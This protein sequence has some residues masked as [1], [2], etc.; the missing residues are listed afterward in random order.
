M[1]APAPSLL[2]LAQRLRGL[3]EEHFAGYRVTQ[4]QLASALGNVAPATVSSWEN[5]VTPKPPPPERLRALARFFATPRSVDGNEPRILPYE[6][7]S[8]DEKSGCR[9]LE[10]EL[11]GLRDKAKKPAR[12]APAVIRRS[13][14]FTD[15]GPL[16]IICAELPPEETGSY[17]DPADPNYTKMQS[18][19][20]L[21][22]LIELHGHVRAEN[23]D[24]GVYFKSSSMVVPDDLSGHV[25]LLGGVAWNEVTQE[26]S[27][28]T[29]LP[30]RQIADPAVETGE[31]FVTDHDGQ[32]RMFLPEWRDEAQT[33]L[34]E[35][36]GLLA[37]VPNPL[38]SDRSLII[39]NGVHSR[40]VLGS[41]RTLT[42]ARLRHANEQ[43]IAS[44]FRDANF[45]AILMRVKVIKN[46]T[47]TPDFNSPG[48]VLYQ[49]QR[50]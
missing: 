47:M 4:A 18:Y 1:T 32:Q 3:R 9:S 25:V 41:V 19:S 5:P 10:E 39:C 49:W 50:A 45:Y 28:M 23:P 27:D 29:P 16:T 30:V 21:D 6:S 33:I 40:G 34:K 46:E 24:M 15:T 8:E 14:N 26:L 11:L 42:D 13:W 7:L 2:Q 36:V 17:A 35:D 48:S 38:N 43:Y 22:A 20:D 37:R 44:N 12:P 31:I